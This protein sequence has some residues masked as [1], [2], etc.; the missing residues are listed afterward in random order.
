MNADNEPTLYFPNG[1]D[2]YIAENAKDRG[3]LYRAVVRLPGGSRVQVG[4]YDAIRL[5]QDLRID[6]RYVALPGMIVIPSVTLEY[7]EKAVKEL[8]LRGY[9]DSL[10]PLPDGKD[11]RAVRSLPGDVD[12]DERTHQ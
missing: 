9:F 3:V 12:R 10:A 11:F 5:A 7:M 1:F 8:F 2:D 6:H 4:F